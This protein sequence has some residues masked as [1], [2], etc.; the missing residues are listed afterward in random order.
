MA[1]LLDALM[2]LLRVKKGGGLVTPPAPENIMAQGAVPQTNQVQVLRH[3][4]VDS[5]PVNP[6]PTGS[7]P[8]LRIKTRRTGNRVVLGES[9]NTPAPVLP[10]RRIII[11]KQPLHTWQEMGW[12]QHGNVFTG[13][14]H[15]GR[16]RWQGRIE[17]PPRRNSSGFGDFLVQNPPNGI[18]HH[19]HSACWH[20]DGHDGWH[21]VHFNTPPNDILSGIK[22]VENT[23]RECT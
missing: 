14:Y 16:H 19:R 13:T 9:Q 18:A 3:S 21:W 23:L 15:V 17:T 2:R 1:A 4:R 6:P 12:E 8:G 20:F 10:R 11:H 5:Y 22:N 7:Q